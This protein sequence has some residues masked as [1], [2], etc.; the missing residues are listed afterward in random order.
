MDPIEKFNFGD[1]KRKMKPGDIV[2][3]V[4]KDL[5]YRSLGIY[6]GKYVSVNQK[7]GREYVCAEVMW[8]P[9]NEIRTCSFSVIEKMEK[10]A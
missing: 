4:G 5:T 6:L 2:K 7:T 10:A 3:L 1:G 8:F 9:N